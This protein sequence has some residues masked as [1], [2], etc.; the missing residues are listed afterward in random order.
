MDQTTAPPRFVR[1][2]QGRVA[3][4]V[5]CRYARSVSALPWTWADRYAADGGDVAALEARVPWTLPCRTCNPYSNP[6]GN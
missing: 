6:E 2:Q 1:T 3:H 5:E 4:S